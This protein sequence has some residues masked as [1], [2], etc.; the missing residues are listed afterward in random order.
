MRDDEI[1]CHVDTG[2]WNA[3]YRDGSPVALIDWD[4][5]RPARPIDDLASAAWDFVPLGPDDF[6]EA[7]GF[8]S[9]FDTARR[10]RIFCDAYD[11]DGG[12]AAAQSLLGSGHRA[13]GTA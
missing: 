2:P 9:P 10:L 12:P 7:C 13:E 5:A 8:A 11:S 3:V 4:G 1:V 6:L